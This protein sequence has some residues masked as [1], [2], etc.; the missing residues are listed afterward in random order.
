MI[1][2][3]LHYYC[4]SFACAG[5]NIRLYHPDSAPLDTNSFLDTGGDYHLRTRCIEVPLCSFVSRLAFPQTHAAHCVM[6]NQ[7]F[8]VASHPACVAQGL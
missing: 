1:R 7:T 8:V 3:N 5:L 6:T 4:P 2:N